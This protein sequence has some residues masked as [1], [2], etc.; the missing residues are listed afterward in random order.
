MTLE[1]VASVCQMEG[2]TRQFTAP[3][4]NRG[5]MVPFPGASV[6]RRRRLLWALAGVTSHLSPLGGENLQCFDLDRLVWTVL[7][8]S[9]TFGICTLYV[10]SVYKV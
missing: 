4:S 1:S 6:R 7:V 10:C 2:A 8:L 3:R 5:K 9:L